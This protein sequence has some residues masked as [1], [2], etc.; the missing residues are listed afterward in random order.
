MP[1]G[2]CSFRQPRFPVPAQERGISK[3]GG[4][5]SAAPSAEE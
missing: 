3:I 5:E 2:I 4:N 1:E